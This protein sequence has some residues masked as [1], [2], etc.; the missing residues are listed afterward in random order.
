VEVLSQGEIVAA[1]LKEYLQRH[2]EI[3]GRLSAT[4]KRRFCT[5]DDP[6]NFERQATK[7]FGAPVVAEQVEL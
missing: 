4:G 5:T 7:F 2:P 3:H 6:G 1:S